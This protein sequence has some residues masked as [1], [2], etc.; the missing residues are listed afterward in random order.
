MDV[1]VELTLHKQYRE[2]IFGIINIQ[3]LIWVW[4]LDSN[5]TTVQRIYHCHH[6]QVLSL[7]PGYD[8]ILIISLPLGMDG[9][10]NFKTETN[11]NHT[12]CLFSSREI[13]MT[14]ERVH[15]WLYHSKE[16]C[17]NDRSRGMYYHINYTVSHVAS[18][19]VFQLKGHVNTKIET[20]A[21]QVNSCWGM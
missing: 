3:C 8:S 16:I 12:L 17:I 21:L 4:E 5:S 9:S 6:H 11:L 2:F 13:C 20:V 15:S 7:M 14:F 1:R 10:C 18:G 19:Q